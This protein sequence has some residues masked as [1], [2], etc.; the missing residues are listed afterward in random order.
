MGEV[1]NTRRAAEILGVSRP[2]IIQ[3]INDGTIKSA[4]SGGPDG[5]PGRSGYRISIQELYDIRD[6]REKKKNEKIIE[7]VIEEPIDDRAEI[8]KALGELQMCLSALAETIGKLQER[9]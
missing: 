2:R 3:M 9:L 5:F 1:V 7:T 8:K 4:Y 6:A